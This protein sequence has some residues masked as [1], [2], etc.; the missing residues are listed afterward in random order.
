[1]TQSTKLAALLQCLLIF[2]LAKVLL[3]FVWCHIENTGFDFV[4][5]VMRWDSW[6]FQS[7]VEHG[8]MQELVG[9]ADEVHKNQANW[10]F[11]PLFPLLTKLFTFFGLTSEV[12]AIVVNQVELLGSM[13]FAYLLGLK[14]LSRQEALFIPL[15]IAFSPGNIWFMAAYSDMTFLFLS[16]LAFYCL[17]SRSLWLFAVVGFFLALSRFTGFLI[18]LP[19]IVY[20]L[21]NG[22]YKQKQLLKLSGQCLLIVSGLIVFMLVLYLRMGDPLAFYHVQGAWNHLQTSWFSHPW[23]SLLGTWNSAIT[24]DDRLFCLLVPLWVALL[25]WDKFYEE[26]VYGLACLIMPIAAGALMSYNRYT[27]GIYSFYL[28]IGLLA[29]KSYLAAIL[30]LTS[31]AYISGIYWVGWLSGKWV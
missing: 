9:I 25:I 8:Y 15:A 29:R 14:S 26:A 27:L 17:S 13:Y 21:R 6:W 2:F 7:I 20:Y 31:A 22:M 16:I 23:D 4:H 28:A 1:M 24:V 5:S 18:I 3:L 19:L 30:I 12:A 11:F 10:A